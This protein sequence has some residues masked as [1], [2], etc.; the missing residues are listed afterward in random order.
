MSEI[1]TATEINDR[2]KVEISIVGS[3]PMKAVTS[4]KFQRCGDGAFLRAL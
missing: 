1:V 3:N 4:E 2:M